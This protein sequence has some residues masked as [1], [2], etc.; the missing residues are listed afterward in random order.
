MYHEQVTSYSLDGNPIQSDLF[1]LLDHNNARVRER[2]VMFWGLLGTNDSR[3]AKAAYEGFMI[4]GCFRGCISIRRWE[5]SANGAFAPASALRQILSNSII[6]VMPA[7][8]FL[9][10]FLT[11]SCLTLECAGSFCGTVPTV[12]PFVVSTL[13]TNT[14]AVCV[15]HPR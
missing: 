3:E 8:A 12:T 7:E 9:E 4:L 6:S 14:Y 10:V 15:E 11:T 13:N 2:L 1:E 5:L